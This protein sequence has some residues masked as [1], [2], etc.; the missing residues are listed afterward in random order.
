MV[1]FVGFVIVTCWFWFNM[2]W[3]S[4]IILCDQGSFLEVYMGSYAE[5]QFNTI[6][7]MQ[8]TCLNFYTISSFN[9]DVF[10]WLSQLMK[11]AILISK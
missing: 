6:R 8:D 7:C 9:F 4:G 1:V 10:E 3:Y 11:K 2:Q 5:L